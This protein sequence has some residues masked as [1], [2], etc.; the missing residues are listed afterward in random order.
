ML[1][2][3]SVGSVTF[4]MIPFFSI[5]AIFSLTSFW[6]VTATRLGAC[7]TG[8]WSGLTTKLLEI[9]MCPRPSNTS[10]YSFR[11]ASLVNGTRSLSC[12]VTTVFT[13]EVSLMV[14]FNKPNL[15]QV[16]ADNNG[17]FLVSTI[18][19]LS[20]VVEPFWCIFNVA[21]PWGFISEPSNSRSLTLL[22]FSGG[23]PVCVI[24]AK[25]R[26]LTTLHV[27]PVSNWHCNSVW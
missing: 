25:S 16:S 10:L 20:C 26:R 2:I 13:S 7:C 6:T 23:S 15:S 21:T 11:M 27:A 14:T 9:P 19:K 12:S 1:L 8:V 5:S 17:L 22:L 18:W 24:T 3:H 4:C